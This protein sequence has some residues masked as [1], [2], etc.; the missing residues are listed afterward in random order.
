MYNRLRRNF[1]LITTI[2]ILFILGFTISTINI[3]TIN[4]TREQADK[5]IS[6]LYDY[7]ELIE[8][9]DLRNISEILN[10]N[11]DLDTTLDSVYRQRFFY[12]EYDKDN[13]V[14]R[15]NTD[16]IVTK[17]KEEAIE[18][19]DRVVKRN[20]TEGYYDIYRYN[21]KKIKDGKIVIFLDIFDE[22][23]S[24]RS[25]LRT[26]I[27]IGILLTSL[28]LVI[29]SVFSK[30]ALKPF[31]DNEE[32][33]KHFIADA[34]HELKTPI[35]IIS[36][37]TE[38]IE[39]LN[40]RSEWTESTKNQLARMDKL[41]KNFITLS[42]TDET[43][44]DAMEKIN[45]SKLLVNTCK[46][47]KGRAEIVGKTLKTEIQDDIMILADYEQIQQVVN[48]LIDNAIKYSQDDNVILVNLNR[49]RKTASLKIGNK[50]KNF[51]K[52]DEQQIF[53]RFYRADESRSRDTGGFGLGL[54]IAGKIIKAHNGK[55]TTT[56]KNDW[57]FFNVE[58][59]IA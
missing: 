38:M 23:Q 45:L 52:E 37:N 58:F 33:Q 57:L 4:R 26:S 15:S 47:F 32:R 42:K 27:Y 6:F 14:I 10:R 18:L 3:V 44:Q 1:I 55:I 35:S 24:Q 40:G 16:R 51:T 48:I 2:A 39:I 13:N 50:I 9:K 21:I 43:S 34:S 5:M 31:I 28:G 59:P 49:V 11:E 36:A 7:Y 30:K 8:I 22:L 29:V 41:I 17:N 46:D 25:V 20:K 54:S 56:Y 12:V 19:A 53:N